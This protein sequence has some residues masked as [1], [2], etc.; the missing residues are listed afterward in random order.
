M[1]TLCAYGFLALLQTVGSSVA[2]NVV[3]ET[4]TFEPRHGKETEYGERDPY[5]WGKT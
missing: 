4:C 5:M 1:L 3:K 2:A